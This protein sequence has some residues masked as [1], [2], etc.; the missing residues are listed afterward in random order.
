MKNQ[1]E[2]QDFIMAS[3]KKI[4]ENIE[5]LSALV[6]K[7]Y[8]QLLENK[9]DFSLKM[10]ID[11]IKSQIEELQK[12][13]YF[14][15]IKR[16]KEIVKLRF[17]GRFARFGTFPLELVGGITNSF[18]KAIFN[19]SKYYQFGNKG[20]A[21]IDRIINDT[22][23]LRLE[24]LGK[25][26]T[27]FYLSANTSPDLFGNSIIQG[28]LDNTF[29]LLNSESIDQTIDNISK[30]GSRSIKYYSNFFKELTNDDLEL[31]MT[32]HTPK[33]A[34]KVWEGKKQK[35]ITLY[36]TLNSIKLSE[37]EDIE[38]EGEIITL[39]IKGKFEIFT[40]DNERIFGT[41]PNNLIEDIKQLHVGDFCKGTILKTTIQNPATGKERHE[42]LLNEIK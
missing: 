42:Y 27:I 24:G 9:S 34:V 3:I 19:S 38:F 22:I 15:N 35:I 36:N 26:S 8:S 1:K 31:E 20:G 21:R 18:S 17:I 7:Y 37:P 16:E 13:L 23:D 39:S 32:W 10:T 33:E 11:N 4:Q 2:F 41:F 5:S 12:Q 29:E 14:E 40:K 6:E 30:V 25:G 28:S